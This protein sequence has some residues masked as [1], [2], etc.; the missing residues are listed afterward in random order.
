M[1]I[2]FSLLAL[3]MKNL[4]NESNLKDPSVC[5]PLTEK[6]NCETADFILVILILSVTH[7]RKRGSVTFSLIHISL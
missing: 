7:R 4:P 5:C 3:H 6:K 2:K 1:V